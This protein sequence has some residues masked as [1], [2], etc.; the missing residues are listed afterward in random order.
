[1]QR[2]DHRVRLDVLF[3]AR[4]PVA[5]VLRRGPRLHFHL[6]LWNLADHSFTH[7]QWMK[8]TIELCDL[9]PDGGKLIYWARQW[10][11]AGRRWRPEYEAQR[12]AGTDGDP[13]LRDRLPTRYRKG[14]RVAKVPRYM[15]HLAPSPGAAR[16]FNE[17]IWTAVSTPPWFSALAIWPCFGHWTGGG[18]FVDGRT[19]VLNESRDA[20]VPKAN[21][22]IPRSLRVHAGLDPQD[23]HFRRQAISAERPWP[24]G[25]ED[26]AMVERALAGAGVRWF[27]FATERDGALVFGCDG[28]IFRLADW[29]A[30]PPD[31]MLDRAERLT[32]LRDLSFTLRAAPPEAMRW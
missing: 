11:S 32:D 20:I 28:Q 1:M 4:A 14:R 10:G 29:R 27:E 26:R 21:V 8:G 25:S 22:P 13:L 2:P 31:A 6:L 3:A 16:R 17:G 30:V 12:R 19:I 18:A 23:R 9:S 7:G 5:V 24:A 15:R